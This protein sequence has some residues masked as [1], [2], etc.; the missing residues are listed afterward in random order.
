MGRVMILFILL[1]VG[2][3]YCIDLKTAVEKALS[4][5][6]LLK[7][8]QEEKKGIEGKALLYKSYLNPNLSVEVG[9]LGTS[10]ESISSN[11]LYKISYLQP[12]LLYPLA[13]QTKEA[14]S[15][16]ISAFDERIAQEKN[17]LKGEVYLAFYSALYKKELLNIAKE[18]YSISQE[19]YQFVRKL[20]D[21]GETTKL[22]LFRAERELKL[23][24]SELDLADNDLKIALERLS[25]ITGSS[26]EDVEG[27]LDE[28]NQMKEINFEE[29]PQIKQY[30]YMI[31]STKASV[32]VEKTLSKPQLSIE[33]IGEKVS[34]NQY[35]IRLGFSATLP[36]F[37]R[38]EGEIMQLSRKVSSLE[39]LRQLEL[40]K[41]KSQYKQL[42]S[43]YQTLVRQVQEIDRFMLAQAKEELSLALKSYRLKTISALE[44][45]DTKRRYIQLVKYRADLLMQAHQEYAGYISLGGQL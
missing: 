23:A 14:V 1:L 25:L 5:Y 29:I 17:A 44:L 35:G 10:K 20:F 27:K 45:Y 18:N 26:V 30:S 39:N 12:L 16:E 15:Y 33:V 42:L 6:P 11:P 34:Q 13:T 31:K 37:Y 3:S 4:Y 43:R 8:L 32:Q 38:R 41:A 19:I 21:L 40:M 36:V 28:L 7:A 22:E 9:N 24:K 2:V